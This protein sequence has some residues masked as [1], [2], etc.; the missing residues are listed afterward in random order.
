MKAVKRTMDAVMRA[1]GALSLGLDLNLRP[2]TIL[3]ALLPMAVITF[4]PLGTSVIRLAI[5]GFSR[6]PP[7]ATAELQ[8]RFNLGLRQNMGGRAI[9]QGIV[10]S[11][12]GHC[13]YKGEILKSPQDII[14]KYDGRCPNCNK[15]LD[16]SP[17]G[18]TVTSC[19][20][21]EAGS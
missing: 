2:S 6:L 3:L 16:F 11:E 15:K 7:S 4:A 18:V 9:P 8:Q 21:D 20:E 5:Y 19:E 10:C 12:C 13:L 17:S 14:K 1:G